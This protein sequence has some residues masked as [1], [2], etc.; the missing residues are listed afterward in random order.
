M[1]HRCLTVFRYVRLYIHLPPA[2]PPFVLSQITPSNYLNTHHHTRDGWWMVIATTGR[3]P[4][5]TEENWVAVGGGVAP[6]TTKRLPGLARRGPAHKYNPL[7]FPAAV[8]PSPAST[9][10]ILSCVRPPFTHVHTRALNCPVPRRGRRRQNRT[11]HSNFY[12]PPPL[13]LP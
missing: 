10:Y 8:A 3:V 2:Y 1:V 13:L 5:A 6:K 4:V 12:S 9:Y 7:L 11:F